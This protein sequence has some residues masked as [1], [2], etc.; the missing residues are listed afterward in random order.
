MILASGTSQA[1]QNHSLGYPSHYDM[2]APTATR[3]AS[4]YV[5]SKVHKV[6]LTRTKKQQAILL[7]SLSVDDYDDDFGDEIDFQIAYRRP[8]IVHDQDELPTHIAD[9]LAQIRELALA[10]YREVHS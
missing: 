10:K 6:P 7:S 9:R 5:Q 8:R 1:N 4:V 2:L 3:S